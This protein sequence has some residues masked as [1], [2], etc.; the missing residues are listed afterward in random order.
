MTCSFVYYR[1]CSWPAGRTCKH[2]FPIHL[3]T[4][5][6][7]E[8]TQD[9]TVPK[10]RLSCRTSHDP[11]TEVS[12]VRQVG[13]FQGLVDTICIAGWNKALQPRAWHRRGKD[14]DEFQL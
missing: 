14:K 8:D 11:V 10:R 9:C 5:L 4:A 12:G 13:F 7:K 2:R 3:P 6:T 1:F